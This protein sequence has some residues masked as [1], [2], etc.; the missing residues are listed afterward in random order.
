MSLAACA[1]SA[2]VALL[3]RLC[4]AAERTHSVA[5][6]AVT[7][8]AQA[9]GALTAAAQVLSEE[10]AVVLAE[11]WVAVPALSTV[12]SGDMLVVLVARLCVSSQSAMAVAQS[13]VHML[14]GLAL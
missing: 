11:A 3:W 6:V 9:L 2:S 4:S 5:A 1:R 14:Q 12:L 8:I 10:E 13:L 7:V